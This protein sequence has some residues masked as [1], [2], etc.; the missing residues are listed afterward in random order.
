MSCDSSF[1]RH[2]VSRLLLSPS[3]LVSRRGVPKLSVYCFL[4]ALILPVT[5]GAPRARADEITQVFD[6]FTIGP[7]GQHSSSITGFLLLDTKAGTLEKA[8]RTRGQ[9][10][11]H[12]AYLSGEPPKAILTHAPGLPCRKRTNRTFALGPWVLGNSR[13][14]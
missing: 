9:G 12:T 3:R 8:K 7:T 4:L 5:F 6:G 11:P 13:N 14:A 1:W 10:M 2:L